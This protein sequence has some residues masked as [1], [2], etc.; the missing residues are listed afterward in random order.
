MAVLIECPICRKKQSLRNRVCNCGENLTKARKSD[1]VKYHVSYRLPNGKQRRE[2][3]TVESDD[4]TYKNG[5]YSEAQAAD[6]KRKSQKYE[7]PATLEKIGVSNFTFQKLANWYLNLKSVKKLKSYERLEDT[8]Q[9]FNRVFGQNLVNSITLTDLED[10]Q[11]DRHDQGKAP[12]TIDYETGTAKTMLTK[13]FD[14]D[15]IDGNVLKPFRKLKKVLKR[16]SNARNQTISFKQYTKMLEKAQPHLKPIIIV[17]FNTGMRIGEILNL[18][19][20]QLDGEAGFIRLSDGDTKEGKKKNIPMNHHVTAVFQEIIQ[21]LNHDY[22]FTFRHKYMTKIRKSFKSCC[23]ATNVPYGRNI[24]NGITFHDI[25]RTVKT[26]MLNS[27]V[28]KIHRDIILG[29]SLDG[30]DAF[31]MAPSED[32]LKRAMGKYTAWIDAQIDLAWKNVDQ[33]LTK[34]EIIPT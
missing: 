4:G 19:W 28:D 11:L 31:Y 12:R 26:N 23:V 18:Q 8:L 13:A 29:H 10:Y 2:K 24:E 5:T 17:A 22:V 7:N 6:G 30:M 15:M 33:M 3:V 14:N 32:D 27:G 16:G 25:R 1:R 9:N 20:K 21:H 34:A